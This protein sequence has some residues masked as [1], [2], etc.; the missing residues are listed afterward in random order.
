[1]LFGWFDPNDTTPS[2]K[3]A[4]AVDRYCEV[5]GEKPTAV[6]VSSEDAAGLRDYAGDIPVQIVPRPHVS[7]HLYYPVKEVTS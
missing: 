1:M 4:Y 2:T 3:V 5:F 6:L 7:R